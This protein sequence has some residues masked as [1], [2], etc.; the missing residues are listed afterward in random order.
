MTIA[1]PRAWLAIF[2]W[3]AFS[4]TTKHAPDK[5]MINLLQTIAISENARGAAGPRRQKKVLHLVC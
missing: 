1:F 3:P 5:E 2:L 4:C